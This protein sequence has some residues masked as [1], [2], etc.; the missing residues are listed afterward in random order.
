MG[1]MQE[2]ETSFLAFQI[3]P[4]CPSTGDN[5]VQNDLELNIG[6]KKSPVFFHNSTSF[7]EL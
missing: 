4:V 3:S 5:C 7:K 2:L 6:L 1:V